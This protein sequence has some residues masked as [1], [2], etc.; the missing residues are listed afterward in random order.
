MKFILIAAALIASAS[1]NCN[2]EGALRL[3]ANLPNAIE[4]CGYPHNHG[5]GSGLAYV[6]CVFEQLGIESV[7]DAAVKADELGIAFNPDW[8]LADVAANAPAIF[9]AIMAFMAQC[10]L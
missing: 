8:T 10:G 6:G 4:N 7:D 2:S 1:A 9:Q 5:M 3:Q